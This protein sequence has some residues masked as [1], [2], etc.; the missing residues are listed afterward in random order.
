MPLHAKAMPAI[1]TAPGE[2]D[3]WLTAPAGE[4]LQL[5]RPLPDDALQIVMREKE[6]AI[7]AWCPLLEEA[8]KI[9]SR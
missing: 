5:Q 7:A 8:D 9:C 4:A 3:L 6:D 2:L 1:L